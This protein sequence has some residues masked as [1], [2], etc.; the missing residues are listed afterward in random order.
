MMGGLPTRILAVATNPETGASTRFRIL[1][2]APSLERAG[3]SLTLDAF[4]SCQ[5]AQT[6]YQ[7]GHVLSKLGYCLEGTMRRRASLQ[8]AAEVA[9]LL[10]IH[11]EVFPL[12]RKLFFKS[13]KKFSGPIVYDYDDAM[14]LPQRQSRG[15]LSRLEVLDA[16]KDVM[17]LSDLVL[18]GNPFLAEYAR[19]YARRVV[20]LPTCIDTDQFHPIPRGDG[21][22]PLRVGW[23]GSHST[24][25]YFMSLGPMLEHTASRHPFRVY[26]VGNP[27]ALRL[28]GIDVEEVPWSLE[29]EVEDFQRC[30]IGLYPLGNDAWA[31][32]KCGFKAIQFM[33]C[34]VPVVASA[35]GVNCDIIRDG[36]NGFLAATE[37]E[38]IEK[39]GRLLSDAA[40]RQRLGRAGRRT[41]EERY[42]VAVNAATF[43]A[44][45][46]EAA[47]RKRR[48]AAAQLGSQDAGERQPVTVS[49]GPNGV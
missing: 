29:R 40:L 24:A 41:V 49:V 15:L 2:W 8:H 35:I 11:R 12:G 26:V 5:G 43:L 27:T 7:S 32:G 18:A 25:K 46:C 22:L 9:D 48:R 28:T 20:H 3:F 30:D 17:Q 39:L 14:F 36:V 16:P 45:L 19:R 6:L 44:S 47:E 10:F 34:G 23:I 37:D 4:F 1:Q 21:A 13:L 42:S 38:W 33:A 31:Q